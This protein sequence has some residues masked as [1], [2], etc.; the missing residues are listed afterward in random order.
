MI[1]RTIDVH[2]YT[3][4]HAK[5][6]IERFIA[7]LDTNVKEVVVVHGYHRGDGL[8]SMIQSPSGIRSKRIKR[9]KLTKNQG[10]T[11]FELY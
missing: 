8:K 11:I 2:G 9:K 10:E 7:S 3:V 1:S 6:E 4:D 5:R